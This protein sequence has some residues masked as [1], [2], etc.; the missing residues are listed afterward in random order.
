MESAK[1]ILMVNLNLILKLKEIIGKIKYLVMN[2]KMK[3]INLSTILILFITYI[4]NLII[5]LI[6]LYII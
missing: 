6:Q 2:I 4:K 1:N 3:K 5:C